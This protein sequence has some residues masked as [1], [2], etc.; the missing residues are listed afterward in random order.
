LFEEL[1]KK[2]F[3]TKLAKH[4]FDEIIKSGRPEK[5]LMNSSKVYLEQSREGGY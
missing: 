5:G 4:A 2:S 3:E 1:Q